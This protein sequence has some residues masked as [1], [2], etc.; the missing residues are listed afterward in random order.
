MNLFHSLGL[1]GWIGVDDALRLPLGPVRQE[2]QILN[3]FSNLIAV[4]ILHAR[5]RLGLRGCRLQ[6]LH[7]HR[8]FLNRLRGLRM[9]RRCLRLREGALFTLI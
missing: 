9:M 3:N 2:L 7:L 8:L 1:V 5:K 4:I 6:V